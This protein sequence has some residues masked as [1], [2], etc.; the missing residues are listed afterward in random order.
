MTWYF[1]YLVFLSLDQ[2][3]VNIIYVID[4]STKNKMKRRGFIFLQKSKYRQFE[5]ENKF[6]F[7]VISFQKLLIFPIWAF[8][9][10]VQC[11]VGAF[12]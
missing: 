1:Q 9:E 6:F 11:I 8:L 3:L 12:L 4:L 10:N 5:I 7:S 2:N